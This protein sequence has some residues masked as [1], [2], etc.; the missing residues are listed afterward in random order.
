M[1]PD[2]A[3]QRS[4]QQQ[5][6]R[7]AAAATA[8]GGRRFQVPYK[9]TRPPSP[10]FEDISSGESVSG[11]GRSRAQ[12]KPSA[13]T[14]EIFDVESSDNSERL[15]VR[16]RAVPSSS[17]K[18]RRSVI[19]LDDST[20]ASESEHSSAPTLPSMK[21]MRPPSGSAGQ[22]APPQPACLLSKRQQAAFKKWLEDYRKRWVSYWNYLSNSMVTE[23]V[24]KVPVT[25]EELALIQGMGATKARLN[26]EGILATIY[27]FLD[28]E[29]LLH[30]FP[31]ASPPTLAECPTWRD[32]G[33][34]EAEEIRQNA[35]AD[36]AAAANRRASYSQTQ[37]ANTFSYTYQDSSP[38]PQLHGSGKK[39]I[40]GDNQMLTVGAEIAAPAAATAWNFN[41]APSAYADR[42]VAAAQA[43][44]PGGIPPNPFAPSLAQKRPLSAAGPGSGAPYGMNPLGAA[45]VQH[46]SFGARVNAPPQQL[47]MSAN[48]P[49]V[50]VSLHA[51]PAG[52]GSGGYADQVQAKKARASYESTVQDNDFDP[53]DYL[54]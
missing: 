15:P 52:A 4:L 3:R 46:S 45:A 48:R 44:P 2:L 20:T 21:D 11:A 32:P 42:P 53:S 1:L 34:A 33:S 49:P 31:K 27:A 7:T 37:A 30:L 14:E 26:G 36:N 8:Q 17:G 38:P 29:D 12:V 28:K 54:A 25:M 16:S 22:S 24:Q 23:V 6:S 9:E 10:S 35:D 39:S 13:S 47:Q 51:T 5:G 40:G 19:A 18:S 41:P 50:P 43:V